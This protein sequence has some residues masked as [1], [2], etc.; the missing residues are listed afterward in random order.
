MIPTDELTKIYMELAAEDKLAALVA[1]LHALW[2]TA[3][4]KAWHA[5]KSNHVRPFQIEGD[6]KC[7]KALNL[8][9]DSSLQV[10][11]NK[12]GKRYFLTD[13]PWSTDRFA[14]FPYS[15]EAESLLDHVYQEKL[16]LWAD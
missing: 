6:W 12:I 4:Y 8:V 15:E 16:H 1:E 5:D 2:K 10:R 11:I 13:G 3:S 9:R 14:A 7:L